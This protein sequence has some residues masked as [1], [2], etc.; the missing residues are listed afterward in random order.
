MPRIFF[1]INEGKVGVRDETGIE[2]A[3]LLGVRHQIVATLFDL[4]RDRIGAEDHRVFKI[5][6]RDDHDAVVLTATL[7]LEVR[8]FGKLGGKSNGWAA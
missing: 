2:I 6:A 1:D 7:T 5:S 3:S 8:S 4:F